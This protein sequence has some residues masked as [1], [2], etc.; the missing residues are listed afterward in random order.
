MWSFII[1]GE[2][3]FDRNEES[4]LKYHSIA[5]SKFLSVYLAD[6]HIPKS[7]CALEIRFF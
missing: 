5:I 3:E 4:L 7:L 1:T 2:L 6:N